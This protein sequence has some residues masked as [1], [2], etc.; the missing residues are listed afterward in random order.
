MPNYP[1]DL[2]FR[3]AQP[4][5]VSAIVALV[6][7]AY[8]GESSKL[9]WTTEADL[10]GGQRT[11]A[12]EVLA[13]ITTEGSLMFLCWHHD[14][15][16][17]SLHLERQQE[18]AYLGMLSI[19]PN[20]QGLGIGK[21]FMAQAELIAQQ[22]WGVQKMRMTVITLRTELIAFY[23]RRGYQRTGMF[24]EFPASPSFGIPKVRDLQMEVL[25][26]I[27]LPPKG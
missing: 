1:F 11:D 5:D 3:K 24:K 12:T 15:L 13:L 20:R 16:M 2:L 21:R 23:E 7:S 27:L 6:N 14:Q 18:A 8:R 25:E 26:K 22:T 9:G 17:G 19:Q 4:T 10:L